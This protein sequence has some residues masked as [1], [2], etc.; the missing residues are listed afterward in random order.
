MIVQRPT[1]A[2]IAWVFEKLLEHAHAKKRKSLRALVCMRM[3]FDTDRWAYPL[4]QEAGGAELCEILSG[5]R[6]E[7]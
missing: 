7:D 4:L 1:P 3:G 2:Q 5:K 6:T